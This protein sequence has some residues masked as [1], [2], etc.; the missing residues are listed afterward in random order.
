MKGLVVFAVACMAAWLCA[1]LL[2]GLKVKDRRSARL[3]REALV[4]WA[5]VAGL[6]AFSVWWYVHASPAGGGAGAVE[7]LGFPGMTSI[8]L[9][10][11]LFQVHMLRGGWIVLS[12]LFVVVTRRSTKAAEIA[13]AAWWA[14]MP[15]AAVLW[16][17]S[18][19]I[20]I[21]VLACSVWM[22]YLAWCARLP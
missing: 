16:T 14:G 10:S 19:G 22:A 12:F 3:F 17:V 6:T 1:A 9:A 21:L 5:L 15:S 20:G 4:V 13:V 18:L 11:A 8:G 2:F 7:V